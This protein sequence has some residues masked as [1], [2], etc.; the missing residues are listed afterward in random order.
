MIVFMTDTTHEPPA[1]NAS[2]APSTT[3]SPEERHTPDGLTVR[4][5]IGIGTVTAALVAVFL[6]VRVLAVSKWDWGVAS[7]IADSFDFDDAVSIFFG[8]LFELPIATGIIVSVVLP[9]SIFRM[10]WLSRHRDRSGTITDIFVIITLAVTLFVLIRSYAMWWPLVIVIIVTAGL[11]TAA[12]LPED[13]RVRKVLSRLGRNTG[14]LLVV[15]LMV[16]A[17]TVSAPWMSREE[18][19]Y[20]GKAIHGY[21]LD[22]NAGFVKV[23]TDSHEVLYLKVSD[24]EERAPAD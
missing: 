11:I 24:I 15:S 14:V 13:A 17:V 18:I 19:T 12:L 9:L 22:E 10:F 5:K 21:V 6:F 16:L 1:S 23:L 8:T 4:K 2:P 7:D 3:G 20:Q